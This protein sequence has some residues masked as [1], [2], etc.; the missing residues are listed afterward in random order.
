MLT[1]F[2]TCKPFKDEFEL[3]QTNALNSW[4]KLFPHIEI[5]IFGN[6][7]GVDKISHQL[8]IR[9]IKNV[10][11]RN[12][13]PVLR[14]IFYIAQKVARY[15]VL[16][17]TNADIIFAKGLLETLSCVKKFLK[18]FLIVGTRFNVKVDFYIDFNNKWQDSLIE[19]ATKY[20]SRHYTNRAFDYFIFPRGL[21]YNLPPFVIGRIGWDNHFFTKILKKRIPIFDATNSIFAI[22]QEHSYTNA[23][24]GYEEVWFG[25]DSQY[26]LQFVRKIDVEHSTD[27]AQFKII[28][29]KNNKY[30]IIPSNLGIKRY[31]TLSFPH[32]KYFLRSLTHLL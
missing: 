14:E 30:K 10:P 29:V 7:H 32:L 26:N 22:H 9:N 17:Y 13:L 25:K 11:M 5:I 23:P 31:L 8:G 6:E 21:F 4:K 28:C 3:I 16:C 20:G 18:I 2:T 24:G 19:Y 1:I 27:D 15:N 12:G